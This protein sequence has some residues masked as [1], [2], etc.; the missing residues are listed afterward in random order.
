MNVLYEEDGEFKVAS[1]LA[2]NPASLHVESPHGR[3]SKIKV[4]QVLL[5]YEQPSPAELLAGAQKYAA[6][7]DT[8]FLWQ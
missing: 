5:R 4:A 6:E 2:T 7:L 1:V 8:D 3:R